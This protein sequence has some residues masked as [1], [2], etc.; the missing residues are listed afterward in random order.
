MSWLVSASKP[1]GVALSPP[2]PS[3]LPFRSPDSSPH[4]EKVRECTYIYSTALLLLYISHFSTQADF[5][6]HSLPPRSPF[7]CSTIVV[8]PRDLSTFPS[9]S[10]SSPISSSPH[11]ILTSGDTREGEVQRRGE[12]KATAS[13]LRSFLRD[14]RLRRGPSTRF[15]EVSIV[16]S[17]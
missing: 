8:A 12:G 14:R 11:A 2:L 1:A 10:A 7:S 16:E 15:L 9:P 4:P 5:P 3:S 17:R 13:S 6:S